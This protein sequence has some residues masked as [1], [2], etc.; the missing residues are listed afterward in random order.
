M[1][2][3]HRWK[4]TSATAVATKVAGR[5]IVSGVSCSPGRNSSTRPLPYSTCMGAIDG[6]CRCRCGWMGR[7]M[8]GP[9][10]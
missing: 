4:A 5:R 8:P 2:S 3:M 1:L 7:G 6:G 9:A 10:L